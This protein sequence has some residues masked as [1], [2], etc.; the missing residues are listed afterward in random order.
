M[1]VEH[2]YPTSG[3]DPDNLCLSCPNCNLSKAKATAASDPETGEQVNL[4]NPRTGS[5]VEHFTWIDEGVR[6]QRLTATGRATVARL[7]M[8]AGRVLVARTICIAA[9]AHSP[10]W[11]V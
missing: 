11:N 5:W 10:D 9:G 3:D 1:H 7:R 4:F 6:I 8:N 2:I